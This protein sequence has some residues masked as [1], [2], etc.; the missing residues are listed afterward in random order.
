M[1]LGPSG[2]IQPGYIS[3]ICSIVNSARFST[4]KVTHCQHL[5]EAHSEEWDERRVLLILSLQL[6]THNYLDGAGPRDIVKEY[7][8]VIC[9]RL[10]CNELTP[11]AVKQQCITG[12]DRFHFRE[13]SVVLSWEWLQ[14]HWLFR[15]EWP[16]HQ[17][18]LCVRWIVNLSFK[19][20]E[21]FQILPDTFDGLNASR[22]IMTLP[23]THISKQWC[24]YTC[25]FLLSDT[26]AT[27]APLFA[28]DCCCR[29]DRLFQQYKMYL[30]IYSLY[31]IQLYDPI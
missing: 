2:G 19:S 1:T 28:P 9:A 3:D 10:F 26:Y 22:I 30:H 31:F 23:Y 11:V 6:L 17:Q 27:I 13:L 14:Q 16:F 4:H 25:F 12:R 29:W 20:T 8:A 15:V 18:G 7:K 24:A 21:Y 5:T